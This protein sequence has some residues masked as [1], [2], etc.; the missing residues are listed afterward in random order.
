P[1]KAGGAVLFHPLTPH[2]SLANKSD[3]Y[4]WSFDLRY[5]VTGQP[6]G[7]SQF[8]Q[9][10]ARS[11]ANPSSELNDWKEWR[12]MWEAARHHEANVE[13]I[14]QHRWGNDANYCA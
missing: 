4:R 12:T 14:S 8:P 10:I 13:H 11:K 7:R 6:T 2:C 1:V 3:E 5:N 9:F